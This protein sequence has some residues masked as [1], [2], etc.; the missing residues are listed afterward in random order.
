MMI[1]PAVDVLDGKVVR[2][3][4]GDYGQVTVYDDDPVET[5]RRWMRDGAEMVHVVDLAGARDGQ[6]SPLLWSSLHEAGVV[7]QVG[8]GLRD[9]RSVEE[10]LAAGAAR[11]V[12]GTAAVHDQDL[13]GSLVE[14]HGVDA[15]AASVDIRGTE[16]A[17]AGWLEA[18]LA[19]REVMQGLVAC[20]VKWIV[21]TAIL[22]DGTMEG[23]DHELVA[24]V[25]AA[26]PGSRVL[27][28]GGIGSDDDIDRLEQLG[29]AGVIVGRA[30]YEG[31]VTLRR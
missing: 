4:Q 5:A 15:V 31:A 29:V 17:G 16:A 14:R 30:L 27:A 11:V 19:W 20:G 9:G 21:T 7:F 12:V 6:P 23:P 22:R 25:L 13:V 1:L 2:L 18:G 10:A 28:A 3:H 24:D 8:G 26:C